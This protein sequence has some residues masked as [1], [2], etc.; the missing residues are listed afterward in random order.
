MGVKKI[1]AIVRTH[2]LEAVEGRLRQL[3]V[4]GVSVT[5]VKGFGEHANF[6][7]RDWLSAQARIEI[8]ADG[9]DV[10][11]IVEAVMDAAYTGAAGDGIVAVLPVDKLYRIRERREVSGVPLV[12]P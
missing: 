12:E 8:F 2:V 11:R 10:D 7:S 6:F 4:A 9:P 1:T 3:G 5:R